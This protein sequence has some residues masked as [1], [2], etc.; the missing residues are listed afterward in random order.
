MITGEFVAGASHIGTNRS[1]RGCLVLL[2][3]MQ[4]GQRGSFVGSGSFIIVATSFQLR[5]PSRLCQVSQS[6]ALSVCILAANETSNSSSKG[7]NLSDSKESSAP[8][9]RTQ[10]HSRNQ[11]HRHPQRRQ[12][13]AEKGQVSHVNGQESPGAFLEKAE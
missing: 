5:W 3:M 2:P 8:K 11:W 10:C 9:W 7:N 1:P 12:S 6:S 4:S 13:L